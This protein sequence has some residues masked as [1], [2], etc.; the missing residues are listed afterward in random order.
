MRRFSVELLHESPSPAL[1]ACH[2]LAQVTP[3]LAR[4]LFHASFVAAWFELA[5]PF[6][7]NLVRCLEVAFQSDSIPPEILQV[8]HLFFLS[9]FSPHRM[10]SF[11]SVSCCTA[12]I[13]RPHISAR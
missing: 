11:R 13:S 8:F 1:R 12:M 2:A 6:Q 4:E 9:F 7:E 5:E 3:A 10:R